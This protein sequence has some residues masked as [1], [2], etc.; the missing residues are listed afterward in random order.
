MSQSNAAVLFLFLVLA[1]SYKENLMKVCLME[2]IQHSRERF[3]KMYKESTSTETLDK[4]KKTL[5]IVFR[6]W[7]FETNGQSLR[8]SFE[9]MNEMFIFNSFFVQIKYLHCQ[10]VFFVLETTGYQLFL[11]PLL[12]LKM[13]KYER[14]RQAVGLFD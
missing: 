11:T 9:V 5:I 3:W 2:T 6:F 14:A 12:Y 10:F 4:N 13:P 8:K 1:L 7:H